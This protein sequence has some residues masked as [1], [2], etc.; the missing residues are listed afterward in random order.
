MRGGAWLMLSW[1]PATTMSLSPLRIACQPSATVRSPEPHSWL[2]PTR[3]G[4][5]GEP[6]RT[7]PPP[8]GGH[9]VGGGLIGDTGTDRRL[10]RRVLPL[11]RRQDLAHDDFRHLFRL[12]L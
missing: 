9:P 12:D 3:G 2:T 5:K 6:A 1:P 10:A 8:P 4:P 11:A 7:P